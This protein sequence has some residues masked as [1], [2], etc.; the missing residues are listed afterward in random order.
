MFDTY[1]NPPTDAEKLDYIYRTLKRQQRVKLYIW[2]FTVVSLFY[3]Y[4][5]L[6]NSMN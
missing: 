5:M 1:K 6:L 2:T 4:Y 3:G